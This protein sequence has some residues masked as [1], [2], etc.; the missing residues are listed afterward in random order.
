MVFGTTNCNTG[1]K[2]G[3]CFLLPKILHKN[4]L[5]LPCDNHVCEVILSY[6][7]DYLEIE[8]SK[9]P[10]IIFFKKLQDNWSKINCISMSSLALSTN[11]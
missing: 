4:I 1:A 11:R 3:A 5:W 6:A 8:P 2:S 9:A 7:W 10:T